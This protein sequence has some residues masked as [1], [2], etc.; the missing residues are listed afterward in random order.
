MGSCAPA[1]IAQTNNMIKT[2]IVKAK[3]K[4][5]TLAFQSFY[6]WPLIVAGARLG[7]RMVM[8]IWDLIER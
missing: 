1:D 8:N 4:V 6:F 7:V 2:S 3:Q 5:T